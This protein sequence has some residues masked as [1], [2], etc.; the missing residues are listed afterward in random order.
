MNSIRKW[1]AREPL[2]ESV[3]QNAIISSKSLVYE[4]DLNTCSLEDLS[5]S[6]QYSVQIDK[7]DFATGLIGWFEVEFSK[8]HLPIKILQGTSQ[9]PYYKPLILYFDEEIAVKKGEKIKGNSGY[10]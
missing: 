4:L 8:T 3:N 10:P 9:K 6:N 2:I 1:A 7:T 5:F